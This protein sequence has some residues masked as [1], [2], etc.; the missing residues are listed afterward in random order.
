[1]DGDI[2]SYYDE[3]REAARLD[4]D[5]VERLRTRELLGRWLPPPPSTVLDV[6]GG[7]GVH[8]LWLQTQGYDVTLV[9]PVPLHVEQ[10]TAAGVLDARVGDARRLDGFDDGS[11][12]AVLLLGPL[13]HLGDREDREGALAE[14]A[15]VLRP[16]GVAIAAAISR[17][18]STLDG[19]GR[20]FLTD[21]AFEAI[22]EG[23]VATGIH[24]NP[25]RR[26]GWFTTAYFHRPDELAEEVAAAGLD[27]EALVAVEGPASSLADVDEW[28][29]GGARQ[30]A[31]LRAIR[32]VEA[33]PSLL[34]GSPHL[35]VLG[36]RS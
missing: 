22:V 1:V 17:F 11:R 35:L 10:A 2:R 16:D 18:A 12:D 6:G 32:R 7:A 29:D 23:D 4:H 9:D 13:Y 25:D 30:E 34:G 19:L 33:E 31:L 20:G 5:R 27:V 28:L 21:P 15:R 36:R 3:G 14:A 26:P 8:A 24:T